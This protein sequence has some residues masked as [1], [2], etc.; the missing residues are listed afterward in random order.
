MTDIGLG[1]IGSTWPMSRLG[2]SRMS[3]RR[4]APATVSAIAMLAMVAVCAGLEPGVLSVDGLT[5]VLTSTVPLVIAA[6]AQMVMM[7][8]GDLDLG[9]GAFVGL[10]T[11]IAATTLATSPLTGVALLAA[12]LVGYGLLG[13]FVHLRRVPSIL[14]TLGASFVWLGLGLTILAVP[15]G[16]TPAWLGQVATWNPGF[17]PAPLVW[18][19]AVSVLVYAVTQ[20]SG[21]GMRLR[22]LGSNAT[23]LERAGLRPLATRVTVYVIVGVLGVLAGLMLAGQ[24]GTGDPNAATDYTLTTVA[25][26]IIGGGAFVGGNGVPFGVAIGAMTLGLIGVVL[27]LLGVASTWQPAVQGLILFV[28]LA[29]RVVA[30]KVLR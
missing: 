12:L 17:I 28:V 10:V 1:A 23:A 26:V 24:I 22:A 14:A 6:E 25:A 18:I 13:A 29:G 30:L 15:G 19:V 20:R 7:A 21:L 11:A 2:P 3:I 16:S 27:S 9:I 8:A 5:L 4:A